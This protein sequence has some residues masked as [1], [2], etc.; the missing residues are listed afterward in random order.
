MQ[1]EKKR[2]SDVTVSQ[3][4]TATNK[5]KTTKIDRWIDKQMKRTAQ[6]HSIPRFQS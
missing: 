6:I 5:G 4:G 2:E 1:D 3:S